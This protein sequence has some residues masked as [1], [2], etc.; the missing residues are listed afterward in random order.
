MKEETYKPTLRSETN[1]S[2]LERALLGDFVSV[3]DMD[4][5]CQ[6]DSTPLNNKFWFYWRKG[7]RP[8]AMESIQ[9]KN[10]NK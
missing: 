6:L 4:L 2:D 1:L 7:V 9:E 8:R 5:N 10:R 3:E